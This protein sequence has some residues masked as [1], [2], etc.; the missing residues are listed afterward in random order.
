[1]FGDY[2]DLSVFSNHSTFITRLFLYSDMY[3][4]YEHFI[5]NG[6]NSIYSKIN[7][8]QQNLEKPYAICTSGNEQPNAV[9]N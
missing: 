1:M 7:I 3:V 6:L 9:F 8:M 4:A 2:C 5:V